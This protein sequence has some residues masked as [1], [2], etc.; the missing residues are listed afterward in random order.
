M[1][2]WQHDYQ[3]KRQVLLKVLEERSGATEA[4]IVDAINL[5]T[6]GILTSLTLAYVVL[7]L[8]A[9]LGLELMDDLHFPHWTTMNSITDILIRK[10]AGS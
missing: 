9:K 8:E 4:E 7:D 10:G 2:D 6:D 3:A 5:F 1:S